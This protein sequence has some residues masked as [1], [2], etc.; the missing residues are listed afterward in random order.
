MKTRSI[1]SLIISGLI[2]F[3]ITCFS[4]PAFGLCI[5]NTTAINATC[6]ND[7][8]GSVAVEVNTW[9]GSYPY[10]FQWFNGAGTTINQDTE[11]GYLYN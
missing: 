2:W 4:N 8:D 3:S 5:L 9:P 10:T 11:S 1:L 7:N 6:F